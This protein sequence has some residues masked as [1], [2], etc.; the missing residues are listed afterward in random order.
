MREDVMRRCLAFS[1]GLITFAAAHGIEVARW[2]AW[3]GGAH[4]PWFLNSGQATV[5]TLGILFVVCVIAGR[6]RLSGFMIAAGACVAMVLILF[7]SEGGPGTIFPIVLAAGALL[8]VAVT[9][10]GS[11]LG[12]LAGPRFSQR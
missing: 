7:L 4:Q 1:L 11:W 2:S 12:S 10:L 3:F 6:R 8:I 9:L 5:F